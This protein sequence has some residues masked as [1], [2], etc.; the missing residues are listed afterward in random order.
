MKKIILALLPFMLI[1]SMVNVRGQT[2]MG[3]VP[4]W[5]GEV[6]KI[7]IDSV[8]SSW[9]YVSISYVDTNGI[10]KIRC[11]DQFIGRDLWPKPLAIGKGMMI[12]Q[13]LAYKNLLAINIANAQG[14]ET[15]FAVIDCRTGKTTWKYNYGADDYNSGNIMAYSPSPYYDYVYIGLGQGRLICRDMQRGDVVYDSPKTSQGFSSNSKLLAAN[16][17]GI[18]ILSDKLSCFDPESGALKWTKQGRFYMIDEFYKPRGNQQYFTVMTDGDAKYIAVIKVSTGE[19]LIKH[20]VIR[21]PFRQPCILY[22][23]LYYPFKDDFGKINLICLDIATNKILWGHAF[24]GLD[25]FSWWSNDGLVGSVIKNTDKTAKVSL[26]ITSNGKE[27]GFFDVGVSD[28]LVF[29][30]GD[31]YMTVFENR[32]GSY[33]VRSYEITRNVWPQEEQELRFRINA[34]SA[35][36]NGSYKLLPKPMKRIEGFVCIPVRFLVES[37]GG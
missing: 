8:A 13:M 11:L 27:S 28:I 31:P 10:C 15:K 34:P 16:K 12:A 25:A 24:E 4:M 3:L 36:V 6:G 37:L 1:L 7:V 17:D 23:K 26:L 5:S 30:E 35:F 21:N 32:N 29:D 22:G 14:R 19:V 9:G 33:F 2:I 18:V 20:K